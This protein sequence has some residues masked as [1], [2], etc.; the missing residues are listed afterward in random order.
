MLVRASYIHVSLTAR[1]EGVYGSTAA[2][3]YAAWTLHTLSTPHNSR[4]PKQLVIF[5]RPATL[6]HL[7]VLPI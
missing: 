3:I 1:K 4:V 6:P 2:K 7:P 5:G